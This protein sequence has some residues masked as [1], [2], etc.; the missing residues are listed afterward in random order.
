[1]ENSENHPL[2]YYS[3]EEDEVEVLRISLAPFDLSPLFRRVFMES[4]GAFYP[5]VWTN[6]NFQGVSFG[7]KSYR[8]LAICGY[9]RKPYRIGNLMHVLIIRDIVVTKDSCEDAEWCFNFQCP[10][11]RSN[12]EKWL[13]IRKIRVTDKNVEKLKNLLKM[14]ENY[15]VEEILKDTDLE[16]T[17]FEELTE[18]F[19]N[20]LKRKNEKKKRIAFIGQW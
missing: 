4:K 3:E 14:L 5:V 19:T 8:N 2:Y 18:M 17:T 15:P 6:L 7:R 12:V 11:N 10:L 20:P 13:R 16:P 9:A 1:M